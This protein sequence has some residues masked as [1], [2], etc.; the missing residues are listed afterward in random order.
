MDRAGE[1]AASEDQLR[2]NAELKLWIE[3]RIGELQEEIDRL[4]E[5]LAVIDSVLRAS[6][7]RPAAELST[8]QEPQRQPA[9]AASFSASSSSSPSAQRQ[10]QQA[11]PSQRQ[12]ANEEEAEED[13]LAAGGPIPE[14][15]ELRRDRG[16][17]TIAVAEVTRQ[18]LKIEPVAEVTLK[19]ETPPFKSF[20]L[21][22]ILSGMKSTDE[23]S[24]KKGTLQKGEELKYTINEKGGKISSLVV[25]NYREKE[26]LAEILNT[27]SWTFS[28][29]LE[30]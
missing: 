23:D 21:G 20:L 9:T 8:A 4:R 18:R 19:S 10:Q 24:V 3:N 16:G 30:K 5:A 29:M 6:S 11:Y 2:R 28:R 26:R 1:M 25:E 7:F 22:K 12:R 15:R 17:E 27:A 14:I 13:E